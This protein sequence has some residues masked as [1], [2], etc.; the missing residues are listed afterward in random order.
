MILPATTAW[1][2][3]FADTPDVV[4][5]DE[6]EALVANAAPQRQREF[7][8]GRLCAREALAKLGVPW[9]PIGRN[10]RRSPRWPPGTV[11]SITHC[12]GYCAAAAARNSDL[13]T[14]GIDAEPDHP[15]PEEVREKIASPDE[16][17]HLRT[18]AR[19]QPEGPAWD[20]LLFCAKEAVY[21]A[22]FPLTGRWLDFHEA[23]VAIDPV[24]RAFV[25]GLLVP[26]PTLKGQKLAG[27]TGRW[28]ALDGL[29]LCTVVVAADPT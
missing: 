4:L 9:G 5:F 20:T 16:M 14:I 28:L 12:A 13:V 6:E 24:T 7:A 11:G 8:T 21:K 15:L 27:F 17:E 19:T 3:R 26:G 2:E 23:T 18:L 1:S 10:E 22:W 29:I 25:V